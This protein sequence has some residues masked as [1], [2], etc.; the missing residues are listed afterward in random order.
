[1]TDAATYS[2]AVRNLQTYLRAISLA[3]ERIVRVPVDGIYDTATRDAITEFQKTRGL[4]PSGIADRETHDLI[5]AEYLALRELE[6]FPADFFPQ[7][8]ANYVAKTGDE[9]AFIMLL[10]LLLSELA[11]VYDF[12]SEVVPSGAFD[13]ATESAVSEIQRAHS[14][15]V[16]GR[17]DRRTWNRI[18]RDFLAF[19]P[20]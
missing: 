3:D 4:T 13:T 15:P 10:Q 14:L 11:A 17:V 6:P 7:S 2:D 19:S 18:V 9:F 8:P 16:N 20:F 12:P 1:M 5:Y